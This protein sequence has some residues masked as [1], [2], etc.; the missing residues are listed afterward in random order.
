VFSYAIGTVKD[1]DS[2]RRAYARA[3]FWDERGRMMRWWADK[4]DALREDGKMRLV[5]QE[6]S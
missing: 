4:L 3:E 2:M 6:K 5:A 1:G